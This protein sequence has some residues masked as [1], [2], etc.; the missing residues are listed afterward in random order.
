MYCFF[1]E[2]D[3]THDPERFFYFPSSLVY[4][5]DIGRIVIEV[6]AYGI[7]TIISC[8]VCDA[9]FIE[10]VNLFFCYFTIDSHQFFF[11][12]S[13]GVIGPFVIYR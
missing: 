5:D 11:N 2:T 12:E 9:V 3:Y 7:K 1:Y 10:P 13:F 6:R 8:F 4:P